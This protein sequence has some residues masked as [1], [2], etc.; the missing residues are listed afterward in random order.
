[1]SAINA[2]ISGGG[3]AAP[4]LR[5]LGIRRRPVAARSRAGNCTATSPC[6]LHATPQVPM[7]VSKTQWLM[8]D[9]SMSIRQHLSSNASQSTRNLRILLVLEIGLYRPL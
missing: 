6:A 7:A 3:A 5:D 1:M 4:L 9:W 2:A 8:A